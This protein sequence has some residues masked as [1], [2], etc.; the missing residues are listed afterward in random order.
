ML[1][2]MDWT[3]LS[4]VKV[5]ESCYPKLKEEVMQWKEKH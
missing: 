1:L 2:L 4:L 3:L 5:Y